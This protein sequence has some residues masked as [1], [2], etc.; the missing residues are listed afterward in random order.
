MF[1]HAFSFLLYMISVV[2][3]LYSMIKILKKIKRVFYSK[4]F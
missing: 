3:V 4:E 2:I 1:M